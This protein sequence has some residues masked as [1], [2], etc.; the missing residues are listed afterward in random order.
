MFEKWELPKYF[1]LGII[2]DKIIALTQC[3]FYEI[4]YFAAVYVLGATLR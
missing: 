2:I 3:L 4:L 1:F